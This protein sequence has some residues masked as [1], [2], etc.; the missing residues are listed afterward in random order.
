MNKKNE[1]AERYEQKYPLVEKIGQIEIRRSCKTS[2]FT[3][4][5]GVC[6]WS[7]MVGE[8]S[9]AREIAAQANELLDMG[10]EL[11]GFH[12]VCIFDYEKLMRFAKTAH[13]QQMEKYWLYI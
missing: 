12:G 2:A 11:Y 7:C 5:L 9:E 4:N 1:R 3:A 10:F 13:P 8:L 6:L